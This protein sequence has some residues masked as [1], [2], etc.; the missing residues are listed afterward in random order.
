MFS[1]KMKQPKV[2]MD[3]QIPHRYNTKLFFSLVCQR[4]QLH[5]EM[6]MYLVFSLYA[7]ALKPLCT[8]LAE[9]ILI[10][11]LLDNI[12][13]LRNCKHAIQYDLLCPL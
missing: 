2:V 12:C 4:M 6:Q 7:L 8:K 10:M 13:I 9:L 5:I 3:K 11:I 1:L